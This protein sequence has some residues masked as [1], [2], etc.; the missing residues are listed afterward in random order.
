MTNLIVWPSHGRIKKHLPRTFKEGFNNCVCT[1]D[2]GEIFIKRPKN[3][4]ARAETWSNYK[5]NNT[6]M[7]LIGITPTGAI[8]FL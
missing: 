5:H 1:I 3:L 6:S 8:T 7:Y 2:C 4:T